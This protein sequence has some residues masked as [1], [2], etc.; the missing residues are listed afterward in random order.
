MLNFLLNNGHSEMSMALLDPKIW[1][2]NWIYPYPYDFLCEKADL[3]RY[4]ISPKNL[5]MI[6]FAV[7]LMVMANPAPMEITCLAIQSANQTII[8]VKIKVC[9]LIFFKDFNIEKKRKKY[10]WIMIHF[11]NS[12]Q[13]F[14]MEL[15]FN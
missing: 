9:F 10:L 13:I 2:R 7:P 8:K 5:K 14:S 6:I 15:L 3:I 12:K 1:K 4:W 11:V